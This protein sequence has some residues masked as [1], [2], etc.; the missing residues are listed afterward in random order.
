MDPNRGA[1][2]TVLVQRGTLRVGDYFV[3]GIESGRVRAMHDDL[4][5]PLKEAGPARPAEIIGLSGSPQAGEQFVVVPDE[6]QAR[7]IAETRLIRRKQRAVRGKPHVTLDNLSEHLQEGEAKTLNLIVKGDV[8]GSV[9]AIASA[10]LKIK[11]DRVLLNILH[12]GVG[13][14]GE[15]VVQLADASDAIVI[16][17]SVRPDAAARELAAKTGVEIKTYNI[18]YDLLEEIEA[19]MKGMLEPVFEE[20]DASRCLVQ[21]VF[22]ITK[23]GNIAGC[24]VEEGTVGK[25]HHARLVRGGTVVWRGKIASLRRVKDAVKEVQSGVECGIG[26]ENYHDIKAGDHIE[27]YYLRQKEVSLVSEQHA[28]TAS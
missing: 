16:G 3:C 2:A 13:A 8:Q 24:L 20:I 6:T 18:I 28:G 27:S 25:D 5:D 23:L 11:S 26:L 4:G 21:E 14:I 12:S 17:F 7:E 9:E 10:L 1:V 19:A 22:R 15:A